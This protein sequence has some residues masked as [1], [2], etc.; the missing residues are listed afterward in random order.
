MRA[1]DN[2]YILTLDG[3]VDFQPE[4]VTQLLETMRKDWRTGAVCGVI[5]PLGRGPLWWFQRYEYALGHWLQKSAEH[6]LGSVLC[7]PG[8]FSLFRGSALSD[9]NVIRW[10]G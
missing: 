7:A 6:V 9:E 10:V 5:R 8:C 2:T 4:A 1:A 3:D